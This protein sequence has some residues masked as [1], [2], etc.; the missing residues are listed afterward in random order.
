M[1][2][3]LIKILNEVINVSKKEYDIDV[4]NNA[5]Y[6]MEKLFLLSKKKQSITYAE[7]G[8]YKGTTLLPVYHFC[9]SVFRNFKLFAIDS[10]SGFPKD[11]VHVN[12]D[13]DRFYDLYQDS[14]I[15]IEHLNSA[16]KRYKRLK[17]D[18]HLTTE[19]FSNYFG[20][21]SARC[22]DKNEI[23]IIKCDFSDLNEK[24]F[25]SE[26]FNIVFLDCD[27]YQSYKTCLDFFHDK[28]S[29][30]VFDEYYSLKYPGGRIAVD[31][32]ISKKTEWQLQNKIEHNPYFERWSMIKTNGK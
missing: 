14:R 5:I 21:L 26:Y 11:V 31:G 28:T 13:F 20:E 27:L 6:V 32:F 25:E 15:S 12:D 17:T 16:K 30:F 18:E 8:V 24:L 23:K 10:Y 4:G 7:C 2:D 1:E 9:S 22:K 3:N 19:Y 29:L